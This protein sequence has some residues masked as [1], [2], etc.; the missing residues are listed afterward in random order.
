MTGNTHKNRMTFAMLICGA[1]F[2]IHCGDDASENLPAEEIEVIGTW[3]TNFD[4]EE[5]ITV[6]RWNDLTI[7]QFDNAENLAIGQHPAD[8]EYNPS[9]FSKLV[10]TSIE[11]DVFH[12][13]YSVVGAETAAE[14]TSAAGAA[15]AGDLEGGCNGFGW[16]EMTRK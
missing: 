4:T 9:K 16:T 13:C 1:A 3:S 11:N 2:A 14:A 12:Y 15:D 5:E 8:D 10:W 6:D 7:V